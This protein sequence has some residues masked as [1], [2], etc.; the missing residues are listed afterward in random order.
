MAYIS[1]VDTRINYLQIAAVPDICW[2]CHARERERERGKTK[3]KKTGVSGFTEFAALNIWRW[4]RLDN[5][6]RF[7]SVR[8]LSRLIVLCRCKG[9]PKKF[10]L[11]AREWYSKTRK[12][13]YIKGLSSASSECDRSEYL[14]VIL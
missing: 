6:T 2:L 8:F 11:F 5:I 13:T 12:C 7:R 4:C 9:R 3:K 14:S 1:I 10:G